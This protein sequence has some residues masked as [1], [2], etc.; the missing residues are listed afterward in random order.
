MGGVGKPTEVTD[1][2]I[3]KL[4]I[5]ESEQNVLNKNGESN[6]RNQVAWARFYLVRSGLLEANSYGKWQLTSAGQKRS[7]AEIDVLA[8]FKEVQTRFRD[9]RKE[10]S[11]SRTEVNSP[12]VG[13][14]ENVPDRPELLDAI[15]A[16]SPRGFE[17]VCLRLFE[18]AGIQRVK[19]TGGPLDKGI[20]GEGRVEVNPFVSEPIVFQCKRYLGSVTSADVRNFR[21]AMA[22]RAEKGVI[23]T[24]GSF[25]SEASNEAVR[26]GVAEIQLIDGVKLVELF[27][28]FSL[29]IRNVEMVDRDFFEAVDKDI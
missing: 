27:R 3:E 25:T 7:L 24:T 6:I 15:Y 14:E 17:R 20:D 19:V 4:G 21:G 10:K 12:T 28:H 26:P 23:L 9:S 16:L 2:V 13:D 8:E 29:G 22:G 5:S 18:A 1:R 11:N